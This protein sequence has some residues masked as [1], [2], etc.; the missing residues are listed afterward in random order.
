MRMLKNI[1]A[2]WEATQVELQGM[3]SVERVREFIEYSQRASI[4]R[5]LLVLGL[6][7]WPSVIITILVDLIPM[8]PPSEGLN[9]NYLFMVRTFLAF[10]IS[11]IVIS[12]QF[13]HSV[14]SVALSNIRIMVNATFT[15]VP[16]MSTLY[17]LSL[18][19][20][21]PLPFGILVVSPAWVTFMLIPLASFLKKARA[22]PAVWLK[23]TNT[24]KTW[25]GQESLVL[26]YPTYFY[27]FTTLPSHAKT[28]FAMLLPI[29]KIL[30]R[31]IMS[32]TVV[33]L[34][35]EIPEVVLMNVE[36]FNSLFMSYCMQNSPSIWTTFGLI[37][38][39]GAQMLVSMH[40]VS[41]VIQRLR[42][43]KD[44][45]NTENSRL[46]IENSTGTKVKSLRRK[47][48]LVYTADILS[49][50][51]SVQR[52]AGKRTSI[53]TTEVIEPMLPKP[54]RPDINVKVRPKSYKRTPKH[55]LYS[56][57]VFNRSKFVKR[58]SW[59]HKVFLSR[60][61]DGVE[62]RVDITELE[63]EYAENVRKLL[64]ITEF[65]LLINYVEIIVPVIFGTVIRLEK[66]IILL[67][68]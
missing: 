27:F 45:V 63:L 9:A 65:V 38:I 49:R 52:D 11:T 67:E 32:R 61:T 54:V 50:Y 22:N 58:F 43:L 30:M 39:D 12:L 25:I 47:T 55:I 51:Q 19:I 46:S 31:N 44:L 41:N 20:G 15:A 36:V 4:S 62:T 2:F 14:P 34:N 24:L 66:C 37:V 10:W 26:I 56:P 8:R 3:Y 1:A 35:D 21:F 42:I 6:M 17:V 5:A 53:I 48:I 28:P 57:T 64:Y 68:K 60:D 13:R 7:P 33:H 18:V 59:S 40:D 23:I 29:I 16:S